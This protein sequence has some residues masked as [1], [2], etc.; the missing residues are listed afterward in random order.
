MRRMTLAVIVIV[1]A[2]SFVFAGRKIA[3]KEQ[4]VAWLNGF[5]QAPEA[6][7]SGSWSAKSWGRITLDQKEG[8]ADLTGEGDGWRIT[9]KVAAK[10]A[11]LLFSY[12]NGNIAYS[13]ILEQQGNDSWSGEYWDG[14][15]DNKRG[16]MVLVHASE[17]DKKKH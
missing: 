3:K 11:Y 4:G 2:G 6:N 12:K 8:Q 9:G 14:L 16:S 17:K 5:A 13:A 15:Q 1:L 10:K 7:I